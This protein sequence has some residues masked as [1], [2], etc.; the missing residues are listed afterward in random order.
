MNKRKHS[1]TPK[2]DEKVLGVYGQQDAGKLLSDGITK[3]CAYPLFGFRSKTLTDGTMLLIA[4]TNNV[5]DK[6]WTT[7]N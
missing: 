4:R 1:Y 3:A 2:P 5:K 6:L 7:L